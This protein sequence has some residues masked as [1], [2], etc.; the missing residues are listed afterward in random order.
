[1]LGKNV[2]EF[3]LDTED[4]VVQQH[5]RW[6]INKGVDQCFEFYYPPKDRWYMISFE[7]FSH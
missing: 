5:L 7:N 2:W 3:M 4:H 6:A 1:M